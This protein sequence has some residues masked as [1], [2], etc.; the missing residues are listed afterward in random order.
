LSRRSCQAK[1]DEPDGP[2]AAPDPRDDRD[3]SPVGCIDATPAF[4]ADLCQAPDAAPASPPG[5]IKRPVMIGQAVAYDVPDVIHK[6]P[7]HIKAQVVANEAGTEFTVLEVTSE[8]MK[9]LDSGGED[10]GVGW[11]VE[12]STN[13]GGPWK[14]ELPV[15][16]GVVFKGDPIR[17]AMEF[18]GFDLRPVGR[19]ITEDRY[20]IALKTTEELGEDGWP[21]RPLYFRVGQGWISEKDAGGEWQER[22]LTYSNVVG[23]GAGRVRFHHHDQDEDPSRRPP[24]DSPQTWV[25]TDLAFEH[26]AHSVQGAHFTVTSGGWTGHFYS[27]RREGDIR[28]GSPS[29]KSNYAEGVMVPFSPNGVTVQV[30]AQGAGATG[31]AQITIE[32]RDA[33]GADRL[34]QAL[35]RDRAGNDARLKQLE[36]YIDQH[37]RTI[38]R[39]TERLKGKPAQYTSY[40]QA[41][42]WLDNEYDLELYR[43]RIL[44]VREADIPE[45]EAAIAWSEAA[46]SR[47]WSGAA[48]ADRAIL[49]A[50][51]R[52]REIDKQMKEAKLQIVAE[53]FSY[54]G[55]PQNTSLAEWRANRQREIAL[56]QHYID[57]WAGARDDWQRLAVDAYMAGDAATVR[58]AHMTLVKMATTPAFDQPPN[59]GPNATAARELTDLAGRIAVLTGDRAGAAALFIEGAKLAGRPW[60]DPNFT[61]RPAWWPPSGEADRTPISE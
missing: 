38:A 9:K 8:V 10:S 54:P 17:K 35:A 55:V 46:Y 56:A 18:S 4:D 21:H 15:A 49:A 42:E 7:V 39:I 47:N 45:A 5:M 51:R 36:G 59:T 27:P 26:Q 40:R 52:G 53:A 29:L 28:Y 37:E 61:S 22:E 1:T 60:P 31:S 48:E 41:Y 50:K 2:D 25:R 44:K 34:A 6:G 32:P 14:S 13:Q 19:R 12:G 11:I 23:P 33:S 57:T 16:V 30:S 24:G 58:E 3:A 20:L 43:L